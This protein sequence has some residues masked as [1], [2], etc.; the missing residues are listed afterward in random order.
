MCDA[1]TPD[2]CLCICSVCAGAKEVQRSDGAKE[3]G[4]SEAYVNDRN[5]NEDEAYVVLNSSTRDE[6]QMYAKLRQFR[7][8]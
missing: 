8:E 3:A 5:R 4:H 2:D 6:P 7:D 1:V